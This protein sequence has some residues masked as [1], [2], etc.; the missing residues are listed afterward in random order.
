MV[1][2][3][4]FV[5]GKQ[6]NGRRKRGTE[7]FGGV[8]LSSYDTATAWW[9][10][11]F[12]PSL[13]QGYCYYCTL[14]IKTVNAACF[15]FNGTWLQC[16]PHPPH[17]ASDHEHDLDFTPSKTKLTQCSV[18]LLHF[19]KFCHV[20]L[21]SLIPQSI[22]VMICQMLLNLG[23]KCSIKVLLKKTWLKQFE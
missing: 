13:R 10:H 19:R 15:S 1:T 17:F 8:A 21:F 14:A 11:I 16:S 6:A 22:S 7:N 3:L 4:P 12:S 5:P 23:A 2:D 20:H 9:L 18:Q